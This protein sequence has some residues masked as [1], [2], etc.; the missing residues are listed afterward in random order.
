[1]IGERAKNKE[2]DKIFTYEDCVIK[3]PFGS[4]DIGDIIKDLDRQPER[5][6]K[7]LRRNIVQSLAHHDGAYRGE[8]VPKTAGL[9]PLPGL[10]KRKQELA[11]L[12]AVVQADQTQSQ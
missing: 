7:I 1:M 8:S 11:A 12:A 4:E 3:V 10:I 6:A 5:Q 9:E 2:F